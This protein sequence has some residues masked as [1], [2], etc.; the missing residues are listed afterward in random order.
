MA[1]IKLLC[2]AS[3]ALLLLSGSVHAR[4]APAGRAVVVLLPSLDWPEL[5]LALDSGRV[6]NLSGLIREGAVGLMN[7]LTAG[8][9]LPGDAYLTLGAGTRA[10]GGAA[11][12]EAYDRE[13]L[14]GGMSGAGLYEVWQGRRAPGGA[15]LHTAVEAM[16][17]ANAGLHYPVDLGALGV[18][19]HQAGLRTAVLGN[20]DVFT[21]PPDTPLPGAPPGVVPQPYAVGRWAAAVAMDRMGV[22]DFGAVGPAVL[23]SDPAFPGLWRTDEDRLAALAADVLGRSDLSV[24]ETGDLWRLLAA[25]ERL[26][27]DAYLRYRLEALTRADRIVGTLLQR[28]DVGRD[29]LLVVNPFSSN[30]A[31]QRGGVMTPILAWGKGIGHGLLTSGTTRQE[32]LVTNLDVAPTVL[33]HHGLHPT[34]AMPGRPMTARY[35][36]DPAGRVEAIHRGLLANYNRRLVLVKGYI[37]L[38]II[39]LG[40]SLL[41]LFRRRVPRGRIEPL[42]ISLTAVP[43]ALLLLGAMPAAAPPVSYAAAVALTVLITAAARSAGRRG[44]IAPFALVAGATVLLVTADVL[45]G[46]VLMG[47]SPLGHSPVGGARYYGIGNEYMGVLIGSSLVAGAALLDRFPGLPL[48]RAGIPVCW[49]LLLTVIGSPAL[50]ANFG[51]LLAGSVGY[52]TAVMRLFGLRATARQTLLLSGIAAA[53]VAAV[54]AADLSRAPEAQSHIARAVAAM[55]REGWPSAAQTMGDIIQRKM[56]M[57]WKLIRWTNW[58]WVFLVSL[59][60]YAWLVFRPPHPLQHIL[61]R[62]PGFSAGLSGVAAG[63]LAALAFNDS[64]IVAAATAMIFASA[65]VTYLMLQR[66]TPERR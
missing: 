19:L 64:G 33:R 32:G 50:G 39:V 17:A 40:M 46:S 25:R 6:P 9:P 43:A 11:A 65:P 21:P 58:S 4:N 62:R 20:A 38:Q 31:R 41:A 53:V 57:N 14:S 45:G 26:A 37:F 35:A 16:A 1:P 49:G 55:G 3:T 12:G 51:G 10:A 28:L 52:A 54:I 34:L 24:I 2:A 7:T 23:R 59:G 30:D 66:V 36:E 18:A 44:G 27:P 48:I 42:L 15:V 13:E 60:T 56:Q 61:S 47:Y 5:R 22:V 63:S 8:R 29:L